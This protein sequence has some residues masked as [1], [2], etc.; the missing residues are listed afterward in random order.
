M[1]NKERQEVAR[2]VEKDIVKGLNNYTFDG[3]IYDIVEEAVQSYV[4]RHNESLGS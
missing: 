1:T 3:N 2:E 4:D